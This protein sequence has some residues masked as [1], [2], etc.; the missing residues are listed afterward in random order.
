[1]TARAALEAMVPA[2]WFDGVESDQVLKFVHRASASVATTRLTTWARI[3]TTKN[4]VNPLAFVRGSEIELPSQVNL[5]Y[6]A[7]AA[8][9]QPGMQYA[10]R[11]IGL[12][13]NNLLSVD[14][15]P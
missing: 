15:A 5:I 3:R 6:A 14:T 9:F 13:S 12:E 10:R 11:L 7:V 4:S 8:D 2:W 1:M